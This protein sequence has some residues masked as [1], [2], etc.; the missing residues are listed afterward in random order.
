MRAT[1]AD[2]VRHACYEADGP[3]RAGTVVV[4]SPAVAGAARRR[5]LEVFVPLPR[6]MLGVVIPLANEEATV[7]ELLDRLLPH[8]DDADRAFCVLDGVSKDGTRAIVGARSAADPRV[9]L[10]W[11]PENRS[12]VDAYFRG[13]R[14]ALDAGCGWILE[15]DGGLSHR[16][17]EVPRFL[18]AMATGVDFAAGS[19]FCPGGRYLGFGK[20]YLIS[21]GGSLL[22]N[23]LLGTRM[24]DMTSGFE[25]F[26][27]EALEHVVERGVR[28]RAHFFQTEIRFM[29]RD[30]R[31]TEVPIT[32]SHPSASVGSSN[33]KEA[34]RN[35]RALREE[36]GTTTKQE[37]TG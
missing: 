3:P 27:R 36:A 29:L 8:L 17:E 13:Y 22:A 14:E 20:R 37:H 16:P 34:V 6:P 9:A 31:W 5:H 1:C 21:R 12:V 25:C 32:Y 24:H 4:R 28:S 26:T 33:L 30:W 11:A 35:L 7:D 23:R 2:A 15:M 10:V 19:R 18:D